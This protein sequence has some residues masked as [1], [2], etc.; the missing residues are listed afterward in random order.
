MKIS[1]RIWQ[2]IGLSGSSH[3]FVGLQMFA[4]TV[5]VLTAAT[6][7]ASSAPRIA[8]FFQRIVTGPTRDGCSRASANQHTDTGPQSCTSGSPDDARRLAL[9]ATSIVHQRQS[10]PL[11]A[12]GKDFT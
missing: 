8:L 5:P 9:P 7:Q 1:S 11:V 12:A 4:A 10:R 6:H 3:D 2:H